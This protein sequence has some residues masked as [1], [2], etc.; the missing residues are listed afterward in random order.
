MKT[1]QIIERRDL[2]FLSE[3]QRLKIYEVEG[4]EPR[5]P[6]NYADKTLILTFSDGVKIV[7]QPPK[8][9]NQAEEGQTQ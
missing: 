2:S 8:V 4:V 6:E 5:T 7:V 3:A 9:K 1:I